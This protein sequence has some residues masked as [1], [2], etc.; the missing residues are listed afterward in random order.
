METEIT[1]S[2]YHQAAD[3]AMN[4]LVDFLEDLEDNHDI[5]PEYDSGV[6]SIIMPDD[7]EYVINKHTPS[8][9]IWVSSPYSGASYFS[10]QEGVWRMRRGQASEKGT[11]P[12][13][14]F[15]FIKS[16]I[17]TKIDS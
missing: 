11:Q 12:P 4:E 2:Q 3:P 10:L 15:E 8:R 14:L 13:T 16:E 17:S 7:K 9:Q 5:S 6:L 1:E